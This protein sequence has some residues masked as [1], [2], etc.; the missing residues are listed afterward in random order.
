MQDCVHGKNVQREIGDG[1]VRDS[2]PHY[3]HWI[4]YI[5]D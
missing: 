3:R 4:K 5:I 1:Q 2:E